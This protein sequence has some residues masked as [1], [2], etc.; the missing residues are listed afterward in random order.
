[1]TK[2]QSEILALQEASFEPNERALVVAAQGYPALSEC[3]RKGNYIVTPQLAD[4]TPAYLVRD[5]DFGVIPK[6]KKPSLL[7]SG[8][9]KIISAYRFMPRYTINSSIEQHTKDIKEIFGEHYD[10]YQNMH[11]NQDVRE[12]VRREQ[13]GEYAKR[14]GLNVHYY[15]DYGW[16]AVEL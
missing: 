3:D 11:S 1:M 14:T 10:I 8:A 12:A 5:V 2:T 7:K 9:E 15:Q 6:T 16:P 13:L 4:T